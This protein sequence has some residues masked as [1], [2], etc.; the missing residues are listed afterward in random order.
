[1]NVYNS[2]KLKIAKKHEKTKKN[3]VFWLKK[4]E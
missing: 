4:S 1:M 2:Y 3:N